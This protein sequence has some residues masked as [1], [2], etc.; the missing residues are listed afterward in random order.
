M[1]ADLLN[2]E[3]HEAVEHLEGPLLVLAGAGSGKTRV[4]TFRMAQLIQKGVLPSDIL[5][6]TFTNKAAEEMQKRVQQL[7][8]AQVLTCTFHS[9]GARILRESCRSLGYNNDF[10]IY[11]DEDTYGLLKQ[12]LQ[13]FDIKIEKGTIKHLRNCISKAKNDLLMPDEVGPQP[14]SSVVDQKFAEIYEF[15]QSRLKAANAM[16]FDD[17]L[18]LCVKLLQKDEDIRKIYQNRWLFVLIDEY[19]D[20]NFA[21]YTLAKILVD[22]HKNIFAVGDP[23][24]SIYS[25]RGAQAKNILNFENDF[26][27]AKTIVLEQNYRSTSNILNAANAVIENN[28][29]RLEKNLWSDLGEGQKVGIF[30]GSNDKEEVQFILNKLESHHFDDSVPLHEIAIFYRTNA[31]SRLLEDSLLSR[32]IPYVIIGG[33]SFY[34]RKEIKDIL[35]YLKMVHSDFDV[36]SFARTIN[37]PKRGIGPTTLQKLLDISRHHSLPIFEVL[38][39]DDLVRLSPKQKEAIHQYISI[40]KNL[41]QLNKENTP[42]HMLIGEVVNQ[43]GYINFL[44]QDPESFRDRKENIDELVTKAAEWQQE[45]PESTLGQFLEELSLK[46]SIEKK[47]EHSAVH[48]MTLHNSKGLE[49]PLVFI[50]GL[51][52][53]ILPHVNSKNQ[54][55][56][57]EEE[58]RLFY[59]G[60]TRAMKYLYLTCAQYRFLWGTTRV[61]QPSRFLKEV[62]TEYLT[63]Y[64]PEDSP[65]YDDH[66]FTFHK[67]DR[68]IHKQ[69]GVGVIEKAYHTS[70]GVTYD[71]YFEDSDMERTLIE[72]YAKLQRY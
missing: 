1:K 40:L 20:T 46:A 23:D 26:P 16:D 59:V 34:Q 61:M 32:N 50:I 4:V 55:D 19:Q 28:F 8:K 39:R 7:Q 69:F 68:V 2:P 37:L 29:S 44:M 31:Q 63:N 35:A 51:E 67:G 47:P 64:S 21:Q 9:L 27:G 38:S 70:Y 49:F 33:I 6:V 66:E 72:K 13:A 17:L 45:K 60:M 14:G 42:I 48:L 41:R 54:S 15:Y 18:F 52:E 71:I 30:S 65:S 56:A 58:R 5:A 22:S 10:T 25:W 43:T 24:Q 53:D 36:V 57:I 62:P 12:C 3:Q 11:D